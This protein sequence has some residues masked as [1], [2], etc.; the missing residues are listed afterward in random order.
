MAYFVN[1]AANQRAQAK[2]I[3]HLLARRLTRLGRWREA[4]PYYPPDLRARLDAYVAGIRTGGDSAR[5]A[6]ERARALVSAARLARDRS[7]TTPR[8]IGTIL[9]SGQG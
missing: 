3:R 1:S 5:T 2:A 8:S 9:S 7:T 6:A 4:R